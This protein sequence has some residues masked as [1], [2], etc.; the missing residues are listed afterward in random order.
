MV[1]LDQKQKDLIESF[2]ILADENPTAKRISITQITKKANI[3]H[4]NFTRY[5]KNFEEMIEKIHEMVDEKVESTLLAYLKREGAKPDLVT[6]YATE[7]LPL[8]YNER[9]HLRILYKSL[10]DPSW[11][12]YLEGKY[13]SILE[14]A[15]AQ[16]GNKLTIDDQALC[17]LI[18]QNVL[19]I[20]AVWLKSENPT[21][22]LAF[23]E[24]FIK[25]LSTPTYDLII[26]NKVD[27]AV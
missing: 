11:I 12:Q 23:R 14:V 10:A 25:Y 19:A 4:Q 24:T 13:T 7:V 15:L 5:F 8:L 22:P 21:P 1:Y 27:K 26:K 3:N 18:V 6:F 16:A 17:S 9:Y 2:F 20:T